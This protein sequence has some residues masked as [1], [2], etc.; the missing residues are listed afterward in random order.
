MGVEEGAVDGD[1]LGDV[2]GVELDIVVGALE[3]ETDGNK[4][5]AVVDLAPIRN[6]Q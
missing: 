2:V 6:C 4:L 5:G 1:K 3:G